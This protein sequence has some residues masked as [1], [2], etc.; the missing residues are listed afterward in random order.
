MSREDALEIVLRYLYDRDGG[1]IGYFD[2]DDWQRA[3]H[4]LLGPRR[5]RAGGEAELEAVWLTFETG[6]GA[7]RPRRG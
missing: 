5:D 1:R 3:C 2:Y 4:A 6:Q 7:P